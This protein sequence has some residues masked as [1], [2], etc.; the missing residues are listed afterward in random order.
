MST[1]KPEATRLIFISLAVKSASFAFAYHVQSQNESR[2]IL[3]KLQLSVTNKP[4]GRE[5]MNK[6]L[7]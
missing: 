2:N 5:V 7:I 6:D 3:L 1:R 4:G